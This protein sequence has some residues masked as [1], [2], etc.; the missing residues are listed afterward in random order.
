MNEWHQC[1]L[2]NVTVIFFVIHRF[3][4]HVWSQVKAAHT[5]TKPPTSEEV[6]YW[7][8]VASVD[9]RQQH[10]SGTLPH[11]TRRHGAVYGN[12]SSA[13][14]EPTKCDYNAGWQLTGQMSA[15]AAC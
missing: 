1:V 13:D 10:K 15:S 4:Y 14:P 2:Y 9:G 6:L 12:F 3:L 11:L 7:R 5:S 8:G